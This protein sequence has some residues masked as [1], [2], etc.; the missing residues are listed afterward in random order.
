M[1]YLDNNA[2]TVMSKEVIAEMVKWCNR[3]NASASYESARESRNMI[4][5]FKKYIAKLCNFTNEYS[6]IFTSGASE[7]NAT[8]IRSIVDSYANV[9]GKK[10]HIVISSIEHNSL[11]L[12]VQSLAAMG[13]ISVTLVEPV[14]SGHISPADVG[15][16]I[17]PNTCL[18]CVMHANNETGA[19]NDIRAIGEIAH[20]ANVP[21]HCDMVQTFGKFPPALISNNIDSA[22][23]SFHKFGGPPGTGMLI[24]RKQLI[25]GYKLNP[26][27]YGSQNDGMRGGTE[28][29]PGIG[30]SLLAT[31]LSMQS[32][33]NK[34]TKLES[35]KNY[36]INELRRFCSVINYV[37]Y[38]HMQRGDNAIMSNV[39]NTIIVIFSAGD[40]YLPNTLLISIINRQSRRP[41]CNTEI[42]NKLES[43]NIIVSIGSACNTSNPRA[44][45][46]LDALKAT[47]EIKKGTLRISFGDNNSTDDAKIF[48]HIM[49]GILAEL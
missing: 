12:Q 22:S 42:K 1:I 26:F 23:V 30:A 24:V 8:I 18:V 10:P 6:V 48:V 21:Y 38:Y 45:H 9:T 47:P 34:N 25:M 15:K 49:K 46:V 3:G 11:L 14:I 19:I 31:R 17:T 33:I 36:I 16:A 40:T 29:I 35:M 13:T 4:N 2:T 28:N 32:R 37:E 41:V 20:R 5:N 39:S 27:I 44:S 43:K 7:S